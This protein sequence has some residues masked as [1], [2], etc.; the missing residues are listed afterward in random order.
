MP[1]IQTRQRH[2]PY[3]PELCPRATSSLIVDAPEPR[4][5][6]LNLATVWHAEVDLRIET[7]IGTLIGAAV[8]LI[9]S[10][11]SECANTETKYVLY[12]TTIIII[13]DSE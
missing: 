3:N 4:K 12:N 11:L 10:L 9:G 1:L 6:R 2:L 7:W 13:R 5:S 8:S